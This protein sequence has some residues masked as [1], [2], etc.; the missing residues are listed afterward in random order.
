MV[1]QPAYSWEDV[2]STPTTSVV[3]WDGYNRFRTRFRYYI[4]ENRSHTAINNFLKT[5]RKGAAS[6]A[7]GKW[8]G[9]VFVAPAKTMGSR[10]AI[11]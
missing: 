5:S 10:G 9:G 7:G 11:G 6:L 2:G 1:E 3:G 4:P 8:R